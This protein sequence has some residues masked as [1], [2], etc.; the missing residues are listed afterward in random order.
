MRD[1]SHRALAIV[2]TMAIF[3]SAVL[4]FLVQP[5]VGKM[6]LP[7]LGGASAVWNTCMVFFQL[8]LLAGYSYAHLLTRFVPRRGQWVVHILVLS[9]AWIVL[10]MRLPVLAID[11]VEAPMRWLLFTLGSMVALPFFAVSTTSPLL[12]RWFSY[13]AH[14]SARSP[15]FLYA[16]SNVGS[17]VAL[18]GYPLLVE[19]SLSLVPQTNLWRAGYTVLLGLIALAG[20]MVLWRGRNIASDNKRPESEEDLPEDAGSESH[21]GEEPLTWRRRLT[22]V[23][24]A[25]VPSSLLLGVTGFLST[26]I[27]SFPLLWVIPLTLYL[28]T[29]VLVFAK[30]PIVPGH[31]AGRV[32]FI[33]ATLLTITIVV[34]TIHPAWLLV[35]SHLLVF[36]LAAWAAHARLAKDAPSPK[37]LTEFF[38]WMSLGGVLG[39]ALNTFVAPL[40]FERIWEYP[41][42]LAIACMIRL[43]SERERESW[44]EDEKRRRQKDY[45]MPVLTAGATALNVLGITALGLETNPFAL[46]LSF[47]LPALICFKSSERPRRFGASLIAISLVGTLTFTGSRGRVL[48][49]ERNF[50]GVVSVKDSPKEEFRMMFHGSTVHGR[51]RISRRDECEPLDYYHRRGPMGDLFRVKAGAGNIG[52]VGLGAGSLACYASGRQYWTF[53]EINPAVIAMA[54][55]EQHFTF[56]ANSKAAKIDHV[57]GDARMELAGRAGTHFDVLVVDAFSSDAIPMHL[58][59]REAMQIYI[60]RLTPNGVLAMHISNRVFDLRPVIAR[61][62]GELGLVMMIR[63]DQQLTPDQIAQGHSP[64]VWVVLAKKREPLKRLALSNQWSWV[65]PD[66]ENKMKT[67]TDDYSNILSVLKLFSH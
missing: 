9:V 18:L 15:Y 14:P 44:D 47:G 53:F 29:F 25:F 1:T 35:P 30:K 42:M 12:Q 19:P 49:I 31:H 23:G 7:W 4:L 33:L 26:D 13:S 61:F 56:L 6:L 20:G 57:L 41:I 59:T 52:I 62:A 27:A 43:P 24:L 63:N 50:F 66:P 34:E 39:G 37:H 55:D 10:P 5:M 65:T 46:I 40:F 32:M 17:V 22:W 2:Y 58:I 48:E 36:F 51:Q 28:L 16:A 21:D 38:F 64:S 60:H 45:L 11:P 54:Q 8:L 67:W 3:T